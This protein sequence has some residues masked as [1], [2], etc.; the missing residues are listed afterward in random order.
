MHWDVPLILIHFMYAILCLLYLIR[1]WKTNK[2]SGVHLYVSVAIRDC[3]NPNLHPLLRKNPD[4][5][6]LA[7]SYF[8]TSFWKFCCNIQCKYQHE[9]KGAAFPPTQEGRPFWIYIVDQNPKV[10]HSL[11]LFLL[12]PRQPVLCPTPSTWNQLLPAVRMHCSLSR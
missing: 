3:R 8:F 1:K 12:N 7:W 4:H 6:D 10:H 11:P 5:W 9:V 2:E